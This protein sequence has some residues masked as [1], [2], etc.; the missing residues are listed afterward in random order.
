MNQQ[1]NLLKMEMHDSFINQGTRR[2]VNR[3]CAV[4]LLKVK[5]IPHSPSK[6][7]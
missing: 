1:A 3:G 6:I 4:V 5:F 7:I 2:G